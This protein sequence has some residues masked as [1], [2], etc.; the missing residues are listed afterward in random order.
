MLI[1]GGELQLRAAFAAKN[2]LRTTI[3]SI[4]KGSKRKFLTETI[5]SEKGQE[6]IAIDS[7]LFT[8]LIKVRDEA[9]RFAIKANRKAKTNSVKKSTL[10][11][12][13]GIGSLRKRA[14][15]KHFK[16]LE[17]IKSASIEDIQSLP[18][19]SANLAK[20]ILETLN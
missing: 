3:L 11:E 12:I 1:D 7:K 5:Y 17:N 13:K 18:S 6:N 14:L 20:V 16:S 9:H 8:L 4:K 15:I 19:F 2:H 10:D